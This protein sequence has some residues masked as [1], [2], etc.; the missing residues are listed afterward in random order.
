[1]APYLLSARSPHSL[2][3]NYRLH[4]PHKVSPKPPPPWPP[5]SLSQ[6]YRLHGPTNPVPNYR[7]HGPTKPVTKLPPPVNS[8][9]F[10][11]TFNQEVHTTRVMNQKSNCPN[12]N[13]NNSKLI[14]LSLWYT[15]VFGSL[16]P[17]TFPRIYHTV[18]SF[19]L[20]LSFS[21]SPPL[22]CQLFYLL[23]TSHDLLYA[24][25]LPP[26]YHQSCSSLLLFMFHI[27]SNFIHTST[28]HV[29]V[30]S[31]QY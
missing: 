7:L 27:I 10:H 22:S 8:L 18:L 24:N 15:S 16:P 19:P 25:H 21:L 1:M 4:G 9:L 12:N 11:A 31:L 28:F 23:N 26:L 29:Y 17:R 2:Y 14:T 13:N 5:Q 6:N 20:S 30:Q 3:Q